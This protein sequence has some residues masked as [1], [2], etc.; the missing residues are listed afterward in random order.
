MDGYVDWKQIIEKACSQSG[1]MRPVFRPAADALSIQHVEQ[2]LGMK[3]PN[4]YAALLQISNGVGQEQHFERG[5]DYV[6][7]TLLSTEEICQ[8]WEYAQE[9]E[10]PEAFFP[11]ARAGVDGVL[12]GFDHSHSIAA[13][14]SWCPI[15]THEGVHECADSLETFL[16]E[17]FAGTLQF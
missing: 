16:K 1:N 9:F 6:G 4:R 10:L 11:F 12:F 17:W 2:V 15:E 13:V 7:S 8:E 14:F 3:V 5:W